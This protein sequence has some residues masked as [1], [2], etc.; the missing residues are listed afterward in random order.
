MKSKV[1][2]EEMFGL[3]SAPRPAAGV[4]LGASAQHA[5]FDAS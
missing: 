5:L 3:H 4:T 2:C 1:E